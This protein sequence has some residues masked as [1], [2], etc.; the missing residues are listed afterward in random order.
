MGLASF[1]CLNRFESLLIS[2]CKRCFSPVKSHLK[3]YCLVFLA[4]LSQKKIVESH[5]EILLALAAAKIFKS[6]SS[7]LKGKKRPFRNFLFTNFVILFLCCIFS[8]P[9]SLMFFFVYEIRQWIAI[10]FY[11]HFLYKEGCL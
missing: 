10:V 2:R 4:R 1:L 3:I 8:Y 9:Y 7:K 5:I 6:M 11:S